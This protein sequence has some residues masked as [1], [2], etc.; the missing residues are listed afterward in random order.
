MKARH[1]VAPGAVVVPVADEMVVWVPVGDMTHLLDPIAT[2]VFHLA[3]LKE[4]EDV[5]AALAQQY[6]AD[7]EE[8]LPDVHGLLTFLEHERVLIPCP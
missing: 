1:V 4:P 2:A 3:Q 8:V 6:G 5:A 7:V